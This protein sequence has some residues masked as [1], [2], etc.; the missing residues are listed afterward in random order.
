LAAVCV[1]PSAYILLNNNFKPHEQ[2]AI[3]RRIYFNK[4][5]H[6]KSAD[7]AYGLNIRNITNEICSGV[8]SN[9]GI[10]CRKQRAAAHV[11]LPVARYTDRCQYA[12]CQN[13]L[14]CATPKVT[15]YKTCYTIFRWKNILRQRVLAPD[16]PH[17][18]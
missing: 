12:A 16:P 2:L 8:A 13:D 3:I 15:S 5:S 18:L 10:P 9:V 11:D 6:L 1:P 7:Y 4:L 14:C 17:A